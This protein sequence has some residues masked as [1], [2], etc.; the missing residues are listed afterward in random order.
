[1][2]CQPN[3]LMN[4]HRNRELEEKKPGMNHPARKFKLVNKQIAEGKDSDRT[5]NKHSE[6][7]PDTDSDKDSYKESNKDSDEDLPISET[8]SQI[9]E[10]RV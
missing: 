4:K 9:Y 8:A 3:S 7:D 2:G 1:M 5:L 10:E 6:K